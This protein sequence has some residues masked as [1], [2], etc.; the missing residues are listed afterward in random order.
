M[1]DLTLKVANRG[2][3]RG[4]KKLP[5]SIDVSTTTSIEEVKKLLAKQAGVR[6]FNRIGLFD[7]T[8]RKN[9]RDR[10]ALVGDLENVIAAKELLVQDLGKSS[11]RLWL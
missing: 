5:A 6:D 7:P 11:L 3:S 4:I 8:T 2:K 1:G 9:I 10:K